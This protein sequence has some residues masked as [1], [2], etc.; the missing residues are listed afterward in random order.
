MTIRALVC[1]GRDYL[2]RAALY[3][4]LND[5]H[6]ARPFA[7]VITGGARGA[8]TMAHEWAMAQGIQTKVYMAEWERLGRKGGPLRNQR[9]LNEGKPNLVVAF[10]G[11]R[12][13]ANMVMQARGVG[14][15]VIEI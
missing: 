9:M 2:D 11:G 13:T 3:A 7:I 1:G 8:D 12:G 10:A 14:V 15:E 6:A 5:L 4:A